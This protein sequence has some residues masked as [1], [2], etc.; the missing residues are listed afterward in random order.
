MT[1]EREDPLESEAYEDGRDAVVE[2]DE[3]ADDPVTE[4]GLETPEA[5]A[6]EQHRVVPTDEDEY[7]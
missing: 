2:P 4:I 3:E 5:D 6:V 1:E 7:R